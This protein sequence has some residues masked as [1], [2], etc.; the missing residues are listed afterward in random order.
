MYK[1]FKVESGRFEVYEQDEQGNTVQVLSPDY[2]TPEEATAKAN[3]LNE[4]PGAVK[5]QDVIPPVPPVDEPPQGEPSKSGDEVPGAA[6][7]A[8][9]ENPGSPSGEKVAGEEPAPA[10]DANPGAAP[11]D[12]PPAV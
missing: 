3:E 11:S 9:S 4:V 1:V 5:V 12:V 10:G 8:G 2:A 6:S 7:G